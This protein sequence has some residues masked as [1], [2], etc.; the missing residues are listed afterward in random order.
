MVNKSKN[1][2][3]GKTKKL[4]PTVL[5]KSSRTIIMVNK[6]KNYYKK[7]KKKSSKTTVFVND[8]TNY[9]VSH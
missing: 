8:P 1:H 7:K 4:K 5:V 9:C 2:Y 3:N 6:P